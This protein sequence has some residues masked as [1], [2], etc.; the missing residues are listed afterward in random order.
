[1]HKNI[2]FSGI[3]RNQPEKLT[4]ST[5]H[6]RIA[7]D[8]TRLKD[9]ISSYFHIFLDSGAI[10]AKVAAPHTDICAFEKVSSHRIPTRRSPTKVGLN[11]LLTSGFPH[12]P[13]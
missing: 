9:G 10:V 11:L 12:V 6:C 5:P 3:D 4:K 13:G 7:L 8:I 2:C 1:M